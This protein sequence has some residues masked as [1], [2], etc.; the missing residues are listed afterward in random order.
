RLSCRRRASRSPSRYRRTRAASTTRMGSGRGAGC[1]TAARSLIDVRLPGS[2]E[3]SWWDTVAGGEGGST[4]R[5]QRPCDG[6]EDQPARTELAGSSLFS[7]RAP[8]SRTTFVSRSL[9]YAGRQTGG[10]EGSA[11]ALR[12]ARLP[13]LAAGRRACGIGRQTTSAGDVI[14]L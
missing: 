9:R 2:P 6:Q 14:L 8:E 7:A 5:S 3:A 12:G 4:V 13:A 11:A 10:V 1:A